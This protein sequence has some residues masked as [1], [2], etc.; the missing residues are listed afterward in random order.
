[1]ASGV[2]PMPMRWEVH[3]VRLRPIVLDLRGLK[4]PVF[5]MAPMLG[6][7]PQVRRQRR[8]AGQ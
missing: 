2:M 4:P 7:P 5:Q 6:E 3:P 1:M 8:E